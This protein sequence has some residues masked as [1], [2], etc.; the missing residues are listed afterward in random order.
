MRA[1]ALPRFLACA[2]GATGP[3]AGR[4]G[5]EAS[6]D[7]PYLVCRGCDVAELEAVASKDANADRHIASVCDRVLKL[8]SQRWAGASDLG[9]GRRGE[10]RRNPRPGS[11][12]LRACRASGARGGCWRRAGAAGS[13]LRSGAGGARSPRR[14][15]RRRPRPA[16]LLRAP[17]RPDEEASQAHR[18]FRAESAGRR[19]EARRKGDP[20]L[21]QVPQ[22]LPLLLACVNARKSTRSRRWKEEHEQQPRP[23]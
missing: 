19:V 23:A 2:G 22:G 5:T 11:L 8:A 1:S 14:R 20:A 9:R 4:R 21:K 15:G 3:V 6:R 10:L 7:R 13:W 18:R 17:R 16:R 12:G